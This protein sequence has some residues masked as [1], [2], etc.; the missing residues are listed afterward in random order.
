MKRTPLQKRYG[1]FPTIMRL[2]N[3]L[4]IMAFPRDPTHGPHL[5]VAYEGNED[6][7]TRLRISD[8][9][10]VGQLTIKKKDLRAARQWLRDNREEAMASWRELN[11]IIER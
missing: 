11:P 10:I 1:H 3:S 7:P 9:G 5:H 4:K 6:N 2:K 8:G